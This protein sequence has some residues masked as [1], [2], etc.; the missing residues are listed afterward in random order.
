MVGELGIDKRQ[1]DSFTRSYTEMAV[2]I[3]NQRLSISGVDIDEEM[4]SLIQFQQQF[5]AAT[6]LINAIDRIYDTLINGLGNF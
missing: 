3:D 2:H 1:A 5:R 4:V 6:N